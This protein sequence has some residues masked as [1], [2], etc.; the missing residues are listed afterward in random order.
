VSCLKLLDDPAIEECLMR[1]A[2]VTSRPLDGA[3]K[4]HPPTLGG[5][6]KASHLGSGGVVPLEL[7]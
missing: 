1:L 5:F 7:E 4:T 3:E 6:I 2:R